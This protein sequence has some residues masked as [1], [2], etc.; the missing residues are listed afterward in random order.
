[1]RN[2]LGCT[3]PIGRMRR[4][5]MLRKL[6]LVSVA[7]LVTCRIVAPASANDVLINGV[8]GPGDGSPIS[9]L[10]N[11]G[12]ADNVT[13]NVNSI[14]I[15]GPSA[16][17][18][19]INGGSGSTLL[20]IDASRSVS[21]ATSTGVY[22][23]STTGSISALING[24][25]SSAFNGVTLDAAFLPLGGDVNLSGT[26][27][28]FATGG[29]A[30]WLLT[31]V[32]SVTMDGFSAIEG[33]SHGIL[34]NTSG[35]VN[36]GANSALGAITAGTTGIEI[37]QL[38]D[39]L[40]NGV[41]TINATD[42][43]ANGGFGIRTHGNAADTAI[44]LS[45]TLTSFGDTGI[46]A[47]ATSGNILISG[48]GT[49][50]IVGGSSGIMADAR[51]LPIG[52]NVAVGDFASITANDTGIW[53]LADTGTVNVDNI[54]FINSGTGG[55]LVNSTGAVSI[56]QAS[57]LGPIISGGIG[58]SVDQLFDA[59]NNGSIFV[60]ATDIT[61]GTHGIRTRTWQEFAEIRVE[62]AISSGFTG[63][64]GSSTTGDIA[65]NIASAGSV[66]GSHYG[67]WTE[68]TTGT[69]TVNNAGL[70]SNA[71]DTGSS[72]D[73]GASSV[74]VFSGNAVISNSGT[75]RGAIETGGSDSFLLNNLAGGVWTPASGTLPFG[76]ANDVVSNA[77]R[78]QFRS[79]WTNFHGL[80]TFI[81][82]PGGH[83]DL[84]F[85]TAATDHV[86]LPNLTSTNGS[87]F[88]FNFDATA[89]NN[90]GAGFD[91]SA[92]GLGTADTIVVTGTSGGS[93]VSTVNVVATGG[94]PT[95]ETGSVSLIYTGVNLL[96][97]STPVPATQSSF[98]SFG[99]GNPT[100]GSVAYYLVDD[101]NGGLYLQWGPN[102]TAASLGSFMG[103][104]LNDSLFAPSAINATVGKLGTVVGGVGAL[105]G[106]TGG[107]VAGRIGDDAS[108][109]LI[110]NSNPRCA[111][112]RIYDT[113]ILAD[114]AGTS[115]SPGGNG[116]TVGFAVGIETDLFDP[117]DVEC[118]STAMGAFFFENQ[119]SDRWLS[120]SS[121]SEANGLGVYLRATVEE[122]FYCSLLGS[123]SWADSDLENGMYS[124]TAS[125]D[126]TGY[127]VV[128]TGGYMRPVS[129]FTF[130]DIRSFASYGSVN[131]NAFT[132]SGGMV[133]NGTDSGLTTL[134]IMSGLNY[135]EV[136]SQTVFARAGVKW[137]D[138]DR[139]V[140][141]P[142]ALRTGSVQAVVG[143][144]EVGYLQAI[145]PRVWLNASLN[146]D[147]GQQF[148]SGGGRLGL[149][150][151]L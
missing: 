32:G 84:S 124:S 31:D 97:P 54:G 151:G 125:Q 15:V 2:V 116:S 8:P 86:V 149:T 98:F 113:W 101:G 34:V 33:G 7:V 42:I 129:E 59:S 133:V 46:Y 110:T 115:Y 13:V 140:G 135:S 128:A 145:T 134:G 21:G 5:A 70:I 77:G 62:G 28:L 126:S 58:I 48:N 94:P 112:G 102:V 131:G 60:A 23:R 38:P 65:M 11:P 121:S 104:Y 79:G 26:G 6:S 122:G 107:G 114:S 57:P 74:R 72:S 40:N 61:S 52:G 3:S 120:G 103:G 51:F 81:N 123:L 68:T 64:F 73:P 136:D 63:I 99:S 89:A 10:V 24:D 37:I 39:V 118:G 148:V 105:G 150:I 88:T 71:A 44:T 90:S 49:G 143:S 41:I 1:M 9:I 132:D 141:T 69:A 93:G 95:A 92:D 17:T 87:Q 108:R 137:I 142:I 67:I 45:G 76:G 36:L 146:T 130:L 75:L 85:G 53:M 83:L 43:T 47:T 56:G 4:F 18:I 82:E 55:V 147:F 80:E 127:T 16:D 91:H 138:L 19:R 117:A 22:L 66:Q 27:T 119:T 29:T 35:A 20:N 14:D 100:T 111:T 50:A 96:A 25:V 106:P 109:S 30:A 144:V 78:I 139:Q 12:P